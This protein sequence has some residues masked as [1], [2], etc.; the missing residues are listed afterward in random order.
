MLLKK[1]KKKEKKKESNKSRFDGYDVR[2]SV[3]P[4]LPFVTVARTFFP[5]SFL[6]IAVYT[7][8]RYI[9]DW[10]KL[11]WLLCTKFHV[12]YYSSDMNRS[13]QLNVPLFQSLDEKNGFAQICSL[14]IYRKYLKTRSKYGAMMVNVTSHIKKQGVQITR[15]REH[16]CKAIFSSCETFD[17]KFPRSMN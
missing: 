8:N 13:P 1:K 7:V 15:Q 6:E 16:F 14:Q 17:L 3:Y 4:I 2:N 12:R 10:N 11:G 9:L 5:T